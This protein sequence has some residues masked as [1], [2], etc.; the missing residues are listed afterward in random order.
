VVAPDS[1]VGCVNRTLNVLIEKP[2]AGETRADPGGTQTTL[3]WVATRP[4]G[5][6]PIFL[7]GATLSSLGAY[8][9]GS[10]TTTGISRSVLR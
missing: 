10:N 4:D 3:C 6:P 9:T 8:W 1:M 5:E 2:P 7:H